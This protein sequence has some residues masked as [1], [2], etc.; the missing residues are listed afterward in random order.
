MIG[1]N[2]QGVVQNIHAHQNIPNLEYSG[3][4]AL[5]NNLTANPLNDQIDNIPTNVSV[6]YKQAHEQQDLENGFKFQSG[7]NDNIDGSIFDTLNRPYFTGMLHDSYNSTQHLYTNHLDFSQSQTPNN[8]NSNTVESDDN[9]IY[10]EDLKNLLLKN[11]SDNN[12]KS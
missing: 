9:K 12:S 10:I 5:T 6:C 3:C 8:F 7:Q 1:A 2:T 4:N 11:M